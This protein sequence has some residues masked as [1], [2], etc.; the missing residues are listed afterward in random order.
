MSQPSQI[1]KPKAP[2]RRLK[3]PDTEDL[4]D[5][6]EETRMERSKPQAPTDVMVII[7]KVVE[8]DGDN[9]NRDAFYAEIP[10]S[11]LGAIYNRACSTR[12][13]PY[14][15]I[16]ATAYGLQKGAYQLDGDKYEIKMFRFYKVAEEEGRDMYSYPLLDKEEFATITGTGPTQELNIQDCRKLLLRN[17]QG[18]DYTFLTVVYDD[19]HIVL[20]DHK[21]HCIYLRRDV[22]SL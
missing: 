14:H 2:K 9:R 20:M 16:L 5:D 3:M 12:I 6:E 22:V 15:E 8:G 10:M 1:S 4:F 13:K 7:S 17:Y 18:L 21:L 11:N 19:N